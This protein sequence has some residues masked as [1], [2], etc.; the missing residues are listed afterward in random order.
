VRRAEPRPASPTLGDVPARSRRTASGSAA[1]AAAGAV[2]VGSALGAALTN[3]RALG[4]AEAG[5][6]SLMAVVAMVIGVIAAL[7]PRVLAWPIALL[8][9]WMG[10]AWGVKGYQLRRHKGNAPPRAEPIARV[11]A[12]SS[13][14]EAK[15]TEERAER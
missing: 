10:V 6:L 12:A 13:D 2:S 4:P 8:L 7:W 14:S 15:R 1:R 5:L 9:V 3:R 11:D